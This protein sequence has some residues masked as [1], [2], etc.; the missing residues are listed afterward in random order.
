MTSWRE[1]IIRGPSRNLKE[2]R[3]FNRH[4]N[5]LRGGGSASDNI[6]PPP[7]EK[8]QDKH[9]GQQFVRENR[10]A[11]GSIYVGQMIHTPYNLSVCDDACMLLHTREG[12]GTLTYPGSHSTYVGQWVNDKRE[13]YGTQTYGAQTDGGISSEQ[14]QHIWMNYLHAER[15]AGDDDQWVDDVYSDCLNKSFWERAFTN[16]S[17]RDTM[18]NSCMCRNDTVAC[19][20]ATYVGQWVNGKRE[21]QGTQ[22]YPDGGDTEYI[23]TDIILDGAT[24]EGQWRFDKRHWQIHGDGGHEYCS[25]M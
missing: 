19:D 4:L 11:D 2:R 24:Y 10:Y 20:G 8:G 18:V 9:G 1:Q 5:I 21:G 14:L 6:T 23:D 25:V 15:F 13:G 7:P 12:Y 16:D 3:K 17:F 22:T